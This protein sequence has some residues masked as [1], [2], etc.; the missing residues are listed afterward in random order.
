MIHVDFKVKVSK[1]KFGSKGVDEGKLREY[2]ARSMSS[3]LFVAKLVN[4][5]T[6]QKADNLK[7]VNFARLVDMQVFHESKV[8]AQMSSLASIVVSVG[9]LI[10]VAFGVLVYRSSQ[11]QHTHML[12]PATDALMPSVHF[13]VIHQQTVSS[14]SLC[15]SRDL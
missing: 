13:S 1:Q 9:A 8:N 11:R 14:T 3:G 4:A 2:F 15:E 6:S 5:A 10:G 7:T 12:L